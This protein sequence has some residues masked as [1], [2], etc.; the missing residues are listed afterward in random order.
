MAFIKIIFWISLFIV[1]YSYLG[2]GLILWL[3]VKLRKSPGHQRAVQPVDIYE[4]YV[5][6]VVAVYNEVSFLSKKI[7]NTFDLDYPQNKLQFIFVADGSTD[8]SEEVIR[9]HPRIKL[10]YRPERLGKVAAVNRAM[11]E[12]TTEF[13]VFCDAN[14]L[15]NAQAIRQLVRHYQDPQV[16][17]VAGEKKVVDNSGSENTAGAGEGLYWKY[18][19]ALKNLDAQFFSV[20]GAAGEL[21]SIRTSLYEPVPPHVLLDD[22]MISMKICL[23]GYR[24]MYEPGAYAIEGPSSSMRDEQK[25]KIRI[26]AGG[27]QS[28][29]LLREALNVFKY[30][31]L[32]FQYISHR[33]LRWLVC[34]ILLPVILLSNV[35]IWWATQ[36]AVYGVLLLL[37]ILF[38]SAAAVGGIFAFNNIKVK[39]LYIPYYFVFMNWA[40]YLGFARFINK[41]QSVLWEKAK[42]KE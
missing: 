27:F 21:F 36:Q 5:T 13:V 16:G 7:S 29:L 31:K 15:L 23:K 24:V 35:Y 34:P 37:Q 28:I 4:P 19:S 10:M 42:R 40:L 14:T 8:G 38:Y 32:A 17:A 41:G 1:F 12:V 30:G 18:E 3:L 25:R 33:V 26:S 20:V 39:I 9:S 2:Y 6:L 11:E 22:F